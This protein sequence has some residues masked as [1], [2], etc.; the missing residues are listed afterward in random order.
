MANGAVRG[1]TSNLVAK[2]VGRVAWEMDSAGPEFAN[3]EGFVVVEK[4]VKDAVA[5]VLSHAVSL[6]EEGL[7][8][9]DASSDTD[10]WLLPLVIL[11]PILEIR[12]GGEM[13]SVS[14]RLEYP[15][16]SVSLLLHDRE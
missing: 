14:V 6:T 1:P 7:H 10:G 13:V 11:E 2:V 4:L 8:L 16:N 5:F 3:K 9:I 15:A 12:G